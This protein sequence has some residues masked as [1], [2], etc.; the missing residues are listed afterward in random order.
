[1]P[2]LKIPNQFAR[3]LADIDAPNTM[4]AHYWEDCQP[5]NTVIEVV[6]NRH[7]G[8]EKRWTSIHEMVIRTKDQALWRATYERGLTEC[9]EISPFEYGPDEIKFV[10][11]KPVIVP[12]VEYQPVG[13]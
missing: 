6:E 11:V 1:M 9:Q 12:T 10:Q 4:I 5:A 8:E 2:T 3:D 7:T 13:D